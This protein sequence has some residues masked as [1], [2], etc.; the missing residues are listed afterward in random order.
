NVELYAALPGNE[1]SRGDLPVELPAPATR[2][3]S[4]AGRTAAVRRDSVIANMVAI[5]RDDDVAARGAPGVFEVTH[6]PG[7]VAGI[8][9]AEAVRP[10][11]IGGR[12]Q[13]LRGRVLR[14]GHLVVAVKRG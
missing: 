10:A 7:K 8:D 12:E 3:P 4:G 14:I 11:D 13:H 2:N 6:A 1:R 9:V 5:P